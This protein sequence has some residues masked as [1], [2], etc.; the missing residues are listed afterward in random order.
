M[1]L[2]KKKK[3]TTSIAPAEEV[4]CSTTPIEDIDTPSTSPVKNTELEDI[5]DIHQKE[6][7]KEIFSTFSASINALVEKVTLL[8]TEVAHTKGKL[9]VLE[10]YAT[11]I[12]CTLIVTIFTM[13]GY[14]ITKVIPNINK[15]EAEI[16]K[17]KIEMSTHKEY[18]HGN[19]FYP[20]KNSQNG[21]GNK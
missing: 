20:D 10:S 19:K 2:I 18:Y 16:E 11:K 7:Q 12:I 4:S 13:I 8:N 9:D 14:Y 1:W 21:T 17:L 3:S 5:N 15:T 6:I